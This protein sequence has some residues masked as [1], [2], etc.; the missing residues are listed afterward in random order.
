MELALYGDKADARRIRTKRTGTRPP[1]WRLKDRNK[2]T[3]RAATTISAWSWDALDTTVRRSV[4][5]EAEKLRAAIYA[6]CDAAMPR[7]STNKGFDRPVYWW[8]L[9]TAELRGR[10]SQARRRFARAQRRR[11]PRNEEEIS[12]TYR[13]YREARRALQWEIKNAKIRS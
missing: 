7:T 13:R 9:D 4:N 2:E 6:A 5:E 10:C 1:R 12:H 3:L 11:W 8:N